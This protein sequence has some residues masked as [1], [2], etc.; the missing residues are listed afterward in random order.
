[1]RALITVRNSTDKPMDVQLTATVSNLPALPPQTV[2][3]DANSAQETGWDVD[4]PYNVHDLQWVLAANGNGVGDGLKISEKVVEAIPVRVLQATLQQLDGSVTIPIAAPQDALR[5]GNGVPRGGIDVGLRAKLSEGMPTVDGWFRGYP[6]ICLEQ[7]ASKALGLRDVALWKTTAQLIPLYL[8]SDGLADY[9]PPRPGEA[10]HG[11]PVLTAYLL[12]ASDEATSLGYDMRIPDATKEQM[13]Q[14]LVRFTDGRIKRDNWVPEFI[15]NGGLDEQKLTA[16]EALSRSG[17]VTPQLVSSIDLMPNQ[18]PTSAVIDWLLV[19]RRTESIP[20]RADRITEAEQIL[21]SR[22]NFQG[23]RLT[24][25]TEKDDNW[26]WFMANADVNSNRI[27]FAV[28]DAPAWKDD[29]PRLVTGALQRQ[30]RGHWSTTVANVWGSLAIERFSKTFEKDPVTGKTSAT[31]NGVAAQNA[32][33]WQSTPSGGLISLRW[34]K[35]GTSGKP[36]DAS[37]TVT[38]N[39]SGKPWL[40]FTSKAAIPL[41]GPLSTGYR[42]TKTV[43]PTEEKVKGQVSRGDIWKV[44]IDIDAQADSTWVVVSDP[45]PSGA[46]ILGSGL[47]RD[48]SI[49][50]STEEPKGR[51]WLAYEERSFEGYR[52]YYRYVPKGTFSVEYTVRINNPGRFGLPATHV[53]AMYAPEMFG[54]IPNAN[55]T[56]GP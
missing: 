13:Q 3:V 32:I 22:L 16:L 31:L 52:G 23:T 47:G 41:S 43:T 48:S 53:E 51:A 2:H 26:W 50:S 24:F 4:V 5:D 10:P 9:F 19:L 54:E 1:V 25:S 37:L 11:S 8:D 35:S 17:K 56:V 21:R 18:W 20:K 12:S 46:T 33:D 6:W 7:L 30:L 28:L 15:R 49:A 38:Q 55:V 42:I 40:S 29:I 34:P 14:A 27:L 39:G 36:E 45:I 44:H